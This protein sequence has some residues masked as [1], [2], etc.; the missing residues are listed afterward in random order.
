MDFEIFDLINYR[1]NQEIY[2][3]INPEVKNGCMSNLFDQIKRK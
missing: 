2:N 3:Q 1:L